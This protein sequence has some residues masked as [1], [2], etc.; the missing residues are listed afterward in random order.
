MSNSGGRFREP[1]R[2]NGIRERSFMSV[3]ERTYCLN[4]VRLRIE[5]QVPGVLESLDQVFEAMSDDAG[6][7]SVI[8]NYS[9]FASGQGVTVSVPNW[10]TVHL[11]TAGEAC[12]YVQSHMSQVALSRVSDS[13]ALHAA[14][15]VSPRTHAAVLLTGPSGSG[16]STL[17][18][19][20]LERG[21]GFLSDEAVFLSFETGMVTGFPRAVGLVDHNSGHKRYTSPGLSSVVRVPLSVEKIVFLAG[22]DAEAEVRT[23]AGTAALPRLIS[24]VYATGP[25]EPIVSALVRLLTTSTVFELTAGA[26]EDAADVVDDIVRY[27]AA[28]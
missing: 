7:G 28:A 22:F 19:H 24:Q 17:T 12:G 21:Y 6:S 2:S 14:G 11:A 13:F 15:L 16:K 5:S 27:V 26:V 1:D 25:V 10:P 3:D 8:L 4:G 18:T 23:L 20:L 9:V